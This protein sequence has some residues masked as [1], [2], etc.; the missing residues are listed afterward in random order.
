[1]ASIVFDCNIKSEKNTYHYVLIRSNNQFNI[2]K[3]AI[4][5]SPTW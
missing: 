2:P 1:M 4:Y 3:H 5:Q